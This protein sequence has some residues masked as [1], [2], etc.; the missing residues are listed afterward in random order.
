VVDVDAAD[1][2]NLLDKAL[3]TAAAVE[4]VVCGG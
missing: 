2:E 4:P 1:F 3:N